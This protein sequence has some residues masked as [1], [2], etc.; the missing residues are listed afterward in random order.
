MH[1][2]L[3]PQSLLCLTTLVAVF[4]DRNKWAHHAFLVEVV[5]PDLE[6]RFREAPFSDHD[7]DI[8]VPD[9]KACQQY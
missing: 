6:L 1:V 8:T 4:L 7:H 5:G 2:Y 3:D 9:K